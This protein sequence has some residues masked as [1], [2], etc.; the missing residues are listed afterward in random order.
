MG[1]ESTKAAGPAQ[2]ENFLSP[3]QTLQGRFSRDKRKFVKQSYYLGNFVQLW[4]LMDLF[5]LQCL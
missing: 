5:L 2:V 1:L 4:H 3:N